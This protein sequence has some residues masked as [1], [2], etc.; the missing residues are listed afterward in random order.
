VWGFVVELMSC[1]THS[2]PIGSM[3]GNQER[4]DPLKSL[5][6]NCEVLQVE[7]YLV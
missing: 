3:R 2:Q 1:H 5:F 7:G 4:F 6:L